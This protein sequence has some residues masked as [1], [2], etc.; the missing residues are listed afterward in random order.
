MAGPGACPAHAD[1]SQA[2]PGLE[3]PGS[4]HVEITLRP[5]GPGKG[6]AI[7]PQCRI[8]LSLQIDQPACIGTDGYVQALT[9]VL[10]H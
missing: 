5:W 2:E 7:L 3:G 10:G 6:A 8:V 4:V 9:Y 1:R